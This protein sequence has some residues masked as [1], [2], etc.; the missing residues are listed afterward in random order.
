MSDEGGIP[1][2]GRLGRDRW[3]KKLRDEDLDRR[4]SNILKA[5]LAGGVAGS[6]VRRGKFS[7]LA[8]AG[9]GAGAGAASRGSASRSNSNP[10]SPPGASV[11]S[12]ASG[13]RSIPSNWALA[14][15]VDSA[16]VPSASSV[17]AGV[18]ESG[19]SSNIANRA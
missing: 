7:R 10:S 5:A 14:S 4:D 9:M 18:G 11:K 19:D 3:V 12:S 17:V 2:T 13:S 8:K 1:L 16:A 6:L 15:I